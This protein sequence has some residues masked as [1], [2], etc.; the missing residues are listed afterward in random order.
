MRGNFQVRFGEG[1]L[2][3]YRLQP[4]TRWPPTLPHLDLLRIRVLGDT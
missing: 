1:R 2:E 4:A 3:K